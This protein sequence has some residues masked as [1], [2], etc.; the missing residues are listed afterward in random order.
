MRSALALALFMGA[1][2]AAADVLADAAGLYVWD[3]GEAGVVA[4]CTAVDYDNAMLQIQGNTLTY[5]ETTCKL[6]NPTALR[7]MPEGTLYDAV[8]NGEGD[9]WSERVM[10]YDTY[11]GVAV[12]SRGAVRTYR[13]CQ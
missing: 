13:A 12:I 9:I 7:D 5:I 8:C 2:P 4:T 1:T 11:A 6:A 3:T 10:V